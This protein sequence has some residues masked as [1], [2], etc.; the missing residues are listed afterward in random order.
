MVAFSSVLLYT[1]SD[2][3][4]VETAFLMG[5]RIAFGIRKHMNG[6]N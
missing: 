2:V 3:L 5:I 4:T 1:F 6:P